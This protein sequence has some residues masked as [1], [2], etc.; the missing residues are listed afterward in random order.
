MTSPCLS[1][2]SSQLTE[3]HAQNQR[4]ALV[5]IPF[6]VYCILIGIVG[7]IGN[8]IVIRIFVKRAHKT[9]ATYFILT[10]ALIDL[11]VCLTVVPF[12]VLHESFQKYSF[13]NETACKIFEWFRHASLSISCLTLGSIAVDRYVAI[14][15]P[16]SFYM[17][18]G[19]VRV[20]ICVSF[21][22]GAAF[23]SQTLWIFG[24]RTTMIRKDLLG[25]R[26]DIKDAFYRKTQHAYFVGILFSLYVLLFFVIVICYAC[27]CRTVRKRHEA[28]K[29]QQH[30]NVTFIPRTT[31][32][33]WCCLVSRVEPETM[34]EEQI[35]LGVNKERPSIKE[36]HKDLESAG[37]SNS[38]SNENNAQ[39]VT[40]GLIQ[41][42]DRDYLA[43]SPGIEFKAREVYNDTV[44]EEDE[45][46][47]EK[48]E[49]EERAVTTRR[50][51]ISEISTT[52]SIESNFSDNELNLSIKKLR[53]LNPSISPSEVSLKRNLTV[54]S[55][56]YPNTDAPTGSLQENITL[57]KYNILSAND[58]S[59]ASLFNRMNSIN[60]QESL[61]G[62]DQD[63]NLS[64]L[65]LE[66]G[67]QDIPSRK[68]D[69]RIL[70]R[71]ESVRS[72]D[73]RNHFL[74]RIK[75]M[76]SVEEHSEPNSDPSNARE[77]PDSC[78]S[79]LCCCKHRCSEG[80]LDNSNSRK[81]SI[82]CCA[83]S[84][85]HPL[86]MSKSMETAVNSF[87]QTR[88]K[89]A[90]LLLI[91][92]IVFLLSWLPFWVVDI[93]MYFREDLWY[94]VR[95]VNLN[96]LLVA[97]HFYLVNNMANPFIYAF[98]NQKFRKDFKKT[99]LPCLQRLRRPACCRK[100]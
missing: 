54:P 2:N 4:R 5:T 92:T 18:K 41:E 47:H 66:D 30:D 81:T 10:L 86:H 8:L 40:K 19:R 49:K 23:Q 48:K 91:V 74:P 58:K 55:H 15:H 31:S 21:F 42:K 60:S 76:D 72:I 88:Y 3:L 69:R 13:T 24:T 78:F 95:N 26:C 100:S 79:R 52:R 27:V 53:F 38:N 56:L 65:N 85:S 17:R 96:L 70:N 22:I 20:A 57:S 12:V 84:D 32:G 97:R 77:K 83:D 59:Q 67:E 44:I 73:F 37:P 45:D 94:K 61:A 99:F 43:E 87:Q 71:I 63:D 93:M 35:T 14:C 80:D 36:R 98:L 25:C 29:S 34:G 82:F 6:Q 90:R 1:L 16:L 50:K 51:R 7:G 28:R 89:T 64:V 62:S 11:C 39:S 46:G 33:C 68:R 75:R 9:S